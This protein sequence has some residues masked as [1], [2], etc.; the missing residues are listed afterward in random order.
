MNKNIICHECGT[1]NEPQYAYCKNCGAVLSQKEKQQ[2]T[3]TEDHRYQQQANFTNN[4]YASYNRNNSYMMLEHIGGV[5]IEDVTTFVGKKS[6]NIIPK[7]CKMEL[8]ASKVSWCW[9]VAVLSYLFG[10][11]GAAI[12]FFYRKMYK[13]AL[14]FVAIGVIAGAGVS[15]IQGDTVDYDALFD[16]YSSN[17]YSAFFNAIEESLEAQDT[18]R[19]EIANAVD[20]LISLSTAVVTALF[21]FY[22]Y[23]RYTVTS[24]NRYRTMG[25]DPRYYRIGLASVGGTSSGMAVLGVGIMLVAQEVFG[26]I[27]M[28][29]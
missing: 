3:Q 8:G 4:T 11:L 18:V 23:K 14:I 26:L 9:P 2:N 28:F 19:T 7:F 10:P 17:S 21:G 15:L 24:I 22:W 27:A 29:M 25:V 12:W 16:A 6:Y 5:P 13:V 1:E 20:S